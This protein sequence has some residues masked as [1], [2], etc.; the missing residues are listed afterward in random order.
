MWM[1]MGMAYECVPAVSVQGSRLSQA[2]SLSAP[3]SPTPWPAFL[4]QVSTSPTRGLDR[5]VGKMGR[6]IV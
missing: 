6:E 1:S 5:V 4:S 3:K 2:P